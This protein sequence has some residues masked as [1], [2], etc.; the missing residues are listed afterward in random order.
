MRDSHIPTSSI[1]SGGKLACFFST[2]GH[3]GVDRIMK[4]LIPSIA[5][6]GVEV[7]LLH[8]RKHGPYLDSVPENVRVIDLGVSSTVPAFFPVMR[9]LKRERPTVLLSDKDKVNR[10]AYFARKAAGVDTRLVFRMGTTVTKDLE[11]KS[12]LKRLSH[13]LSMHHLYPQISTVIVPS[14][15]VAD[16]MSLFAEIDRSH[17]TVVH[18][19]IVTPNFLNKVKQAAEHPWLSDSEI[20]V[21]LGVGE[22]SG[23]KAFDVL[24]NAF[25]LVRRQR[26]CRLILVGKGRKREE[27]EALVSKLELTESVSIVG[28]QENPFSYMSEADVFVSASTFEGFG[29]VI[30]EA[31][32]AG[33]P[34]VAT[35]C[36][37]GPREILKDG[38]LGHLVPV[39]DEQA[40]ADAISSMLDK[41]TSKGVL[42]DAVNDYHIDT[43]TD[44]YLTA[45]GLG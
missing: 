34:V 37:S 16:D 8:V 28:F 24:I 32:A 26:L 12:K 17:I 40:M 20:P 33:T 14:A 19:P 39:N 5:A 18:N 31:M 35:D 6:R 13:Y 2:S 27:L 44:Q 1:V 9:Y 29:N 36:P 42:A 30:V 23:R 22:L 10:L 7:D 25:S 11:G 41:P 43:I 4:N 45:L 15:G 3:S 21:I 38:R